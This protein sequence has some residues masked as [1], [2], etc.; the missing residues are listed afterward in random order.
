MI[1]I[2]GGAAA[3]AAMSAASAKR[4]RIAV[5]ELVALLSHVNEISR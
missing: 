2:S 1:G 5:A 3:A 4:K